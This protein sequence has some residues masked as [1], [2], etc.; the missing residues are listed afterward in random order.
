MSNRKQDIK[1]LQDRI[2]SLDDQLKRAVADYRNLEKRVS[3]GRSDFTS[4]ATAGLVKKL[5]P[6]LDNLDQAVEG[7]SQ[8]EAS[9]SWLAG[10]VMSVRQLRQVLAEEGLAEIVAEGRFDPAQH[11]AVDVRE[12]EDGKILEVVL[13]GYILQGKVLRPAKV[14]VGKKI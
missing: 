13:R 11:E 6:I 12:G 10:V 5:L 2:A 4:W 7:A 3:E 8:A 1:Q 9:S 14:V